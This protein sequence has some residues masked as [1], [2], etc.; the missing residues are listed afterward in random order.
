MRSAV[1]EVLSPPEYVRT[2]SRIATSMAQMPK[3]DQITVALE[4]SF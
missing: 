4:P 3:R 1:A 2:A